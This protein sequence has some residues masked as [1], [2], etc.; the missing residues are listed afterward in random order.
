M[1]ISEVCAIYA[2]SADTL[3]Y[4][5]KIGL[6]DPVQRNA[7]GIRNY[8]E[9]D[10]RRIEFIRHMRNAGLSIEVLTHYIELFHQGNQTIPARKQI[11]QEQK[12]LLRTK[13]M[14]MQATLDR[15]EFKIEN[16]DK[17]LLK[18]EQERMAIQDQAE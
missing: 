5:E 17:I 12:L 1:T 3:R 8:R 11:L 7:S 2:V 14:E 4:Y 13:I 10:L 6:L 9:S 15:L 18:H 16:Y